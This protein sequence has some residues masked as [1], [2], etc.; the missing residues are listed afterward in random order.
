MLWGW[1]RS[2][3]CSS[4]CYSLEPVTRSSPPL[5]TQIALDV[6]DAGR[7]ALGGS[8]GPEID[9]VEGRLIERSNGEYLLGVTS[10][11]LLKGGGVQ[12]WKGEQV[13]LKPEFVSTVYERRLDK[14]RT[15]LFAAAIVG[16]VVAIASQQ[17]LTS[18]TEQN[19]EPPDSGTDE[20]HTPSSAYPSCRFRFQEF[21]S[22]A[23]CSRLGEST[24]TEYFMRRIVQLSIACLAAGV[25]SACSGRDAV[26][27]TG[28]HPHRRRAVHQRGAGYRRIGRMDFRF[29]DLVENNA[30]Y[31]IPFRNNI[32]DVGRRTGSTQIQYKATAAG[33]RHFRIFLD[34]TL[35]AVAQQ[36][37]GCAAAATTCIGDSTMTVED[38]HRYTAMLWG[39]LARWRD[40]DEAHDHRRS[41]RCRVTR[42]QIGLRV[43]NATTSTTSTSASTRARRC[44][45]RR[46]GPDSRRCRCRPASPYRHVVREHQVQRAEP[47]AAARTTFDGRYRAHRYRQWNAGERLLRRHGLRRDAGHVAAGSVVTAIIFP[48]SVAGQQGSAVHHTGDVVHVGST[49][50][51][52]Q[53]H[54]TAFDQPKRAAGQ[55]AALFVCARPL[56]AQRPKASLQRIP[57]QVSCRA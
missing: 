14:A 23:G 6:N 27:E 55:P 8:M 3:V 12:T 47:R 31:N 43:I 30:Q 11:S 40:A 26:T 53:G 18:G 4:G 37:V 54:L 36:R 19:D 35:T 49:S 33:D 22:L 25:V 28:R 7:V 50:E 9:R 2:I 42:T 44:R 34:D 20:S 17:L 48:P 41:V 15:G 56:C 21:L 1:R 51:S 16:G 38:S 29:V 13:V 57:T 24:P 10:V 45:R 52:K 39:K 32:D 46:H 5:G